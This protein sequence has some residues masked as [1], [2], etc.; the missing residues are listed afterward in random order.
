MTRFYRSGRLALGLALLALATPSWAA[1]LTIVH[2]N[3]SH[4]HLEAFG[5]KDRHLDG[6]LGG[7]AKAATVVRAARGP[8][9]QSVVLHAG[10]FFE[11]DIF[12]NATFGSTELSLLKQIGFDALTLGNHDVRYGAGALLF[13]LSNAQFQAPQLL[14]ANI[15]LGSLAG[16][17][18][19]ALA[20][21]V[22]PRMVKPLDGLKV[23]IFGMTTPYDAVQG[24]L[25][26][27]KDEA[28][29]VA[30][31]EQVQALRAEGA[32]VVICL[33]HLGF[34]LDQQLAALA[35][36]KLDANGLP[37]IDVIVGG[38]DH[39]AFAAP[40][41][42]ARPGGRTTW[43]VQA[44]QNYEKVGRMQLSVEG[45]V[46]SLV[47]YALLPVDRKVVRAPDIEARVE[48]VTENLV[49]PRFGDMFHTPIAWA[50]VDLEEKFEPARPRRDTA[51]G[52]LVADALRAATGAPIG[53]TTLG[54]TSDKIYAGAVVP[55]DLFRTV[56]Y[57]Y[58]ASTGL[59]WPI[60]TFDILGAEIGAIFEYGID[61]YLRYG[62][63]D[64]YPQVSGMTVAYDSRRPFGSRIVAAFVDGKPLDPAAPYQCAG[65]F[66]L[67]EGLKQLLAGFGL[68]PIANVTMTP[69]DEYQALR[70]H[71][72]ERGIIFPA[73]VP[74][75]V[76]VGVVARR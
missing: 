63:E 44:G 56:P 41:S 76:D 48:G 35:A 32:D 64:F 72:E 21:L 33:S 28:M 75:I 18:Y 29:F 1:T 4:S 74:R 26:L 68:P 46:V 30:A 2:V 43:I 19:A 22:A 20:G 71:V 50:F 58:D 9:S 49:K 73:P 38:H 54:L 16:T 51:V 55:D 61:L 40:Q 39:F 52:D 60:G 23:G 69:T 57:G 8:E 36:A 6:T 70:T 15:D 3:D 59:D 7:I 47:D 67:I 13:A 17:D 10:D 12:F 37:G 53:V 24:G 27:L 25:D 66:V 65:N 34:A 11:G 45:G 42:V 31:L 62:N 5:P 14:S